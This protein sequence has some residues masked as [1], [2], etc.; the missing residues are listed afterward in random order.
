MLN[1]E[2]KD[3]ICYSLIY[4]GLLVLHVIGIRI[5]KNLYIYIYIFGEEH[6]DKTDYEEFDEKP[7]GTLIENFLEE[8]INTSDCFFRFTY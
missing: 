2:V 1:Y 7:R 5:I 6:S 4:E 3:K 8:V